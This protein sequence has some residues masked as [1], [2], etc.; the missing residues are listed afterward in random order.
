MQFL[1]QVVEMVIYE[2]IIPLIFDND[3][4]HVMQPYLD[5]NDVVF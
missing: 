2:L 4:F 1:E 5:E 3:E